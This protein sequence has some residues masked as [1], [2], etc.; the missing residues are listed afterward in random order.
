[1]LGR[2]GGYDD[3]RVREIGES[4]RRLRLPHALFRREDAVGL[5]VRD[6]AWLGLFDIAVD[7]ARRRAGAGRVLSAS[8]LTW[9][10]SSGAER[11]YLR[12]RSW[13]QRV[14][15]LHRRFGFME[16]FW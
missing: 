10:R 9:G 3:T 12:V 8:M 5:A 14:L 6:G 7:P 2:F 13:K 16:G 4:L 15:V 11:G 1:R